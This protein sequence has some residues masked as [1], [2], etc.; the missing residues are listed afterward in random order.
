MDI[1]LYTCLPLFTM[2]SGSS[3]GCK[4]A[5]LLCKADNVGIHIWSFTHL[6]MC[7]TVNLQICWLQTCKSVWMLSVTASILQFLFY[8][9]FFCCCNGQISLQTSIRVRVLL[10]SSQTSE[11]HQSKEEDSHF[12]AGRWFFKILFRNWRI[13]CAVVGTDHRYTQYPCTWTVIPLLAQTRSIDGALGSKL[14]AC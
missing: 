8:I 14:S 12:S 10:L 7:W 1:V 2:C 11:E 9:L 4:F 6:L 13:E 5:H 3:T